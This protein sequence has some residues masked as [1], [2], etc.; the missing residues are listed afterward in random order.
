MCDSAFYQQS[1]SSEY[2]QNSSFINGLEGVSVSLNTSLQILPS[3]LVQ[4]FSLCI[5]LYW[6][7]DN[8]YLSNCYKVRFISRVNSRYFIYQATAGSEINNISRVYEWNKR[9][10]S[11]WIRCFIL[12]GWVNWWGRAWILLNIRLNIRTWSISFMRMRRFLLYFTPPNGPPFD[13]VK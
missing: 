6:L 9:P 3:S 10:F 5:W 1:V 2:I 12:R 7:T 13:G 8:S 11:S 4:Y